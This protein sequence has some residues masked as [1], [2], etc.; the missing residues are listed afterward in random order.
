[1]KLSTDISNLAFRLDNTTDTKEYPDLYF[2]LEVL[3]RA[4]K[5]YENRC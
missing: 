4:I 3:K 2:S 1:M 5:D